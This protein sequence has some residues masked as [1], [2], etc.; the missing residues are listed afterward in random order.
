MCA[1]SVKRLLIVSFFAL[2]SLLAVAQKETIV[3]GQIFDR[4][5]QQPIAKASIGFKNT[6][7]VTESNDEGY[8]LLRG[9]GVYPFLTVSCKGYKNTRIHIKPNT[10]AEV[11]VWLTSADPSDIPLE[12]VIEDPLSHYVVQQA[13]QHKLFN[14]PPTGYSPTTLSERLKAYAYH[15]PANWLKDDKIKQGITWPPDSL[16]T[17]PLFT[18]DRIYRQPSFPSLRRDRSM[19]KNNEITILPLDKEYVEKLVG[20]LTLQQNFYNEHVEILGKYFLSPLATSARLHYTY[21]LQDSLVISGRRCYRIGFRPRQKRKLLLS[22]SMVID[23][24]SWALVQMDANIPPTLSV[25]FVHRFNIRQEFFLYRGQWYYKKIN[26]QLVMELPA[27]ISVRQKPLLGVVD[28]EQLFVQPQPDDKDLQELVG[29]R[30]P[31][32]KP[33]SDSLYAGV[34]HL[35]ET[36]FMKEIKWV[37]DLFMYQYA[38]VGKIDIGPVS[39]LYHRNVIDGSMGA[40]SLRTGESMWKNFSVGGSVGYAIDNRTWKFGGQMQYRFPTKAFQEIDF[41]YTKNTYQTGF[42]ENIFLVDENKTALSD[43]DTFASL[44]RYKP[45]YTVNEEGA[46]KVQYQREWSREFKTTVTLFDNR[47]YSNPYVQ[48]LSPQGD[49]MNS[50]WNVGGKI[51]FRFSQDQLIW[52]GFFGR[53]FLSSYSPVFH[54]QVE[55]GTY[56]VGNISGDYSRIHTTVSQSIDFIGGNLYYT[57]EAGYIFGRV[58]FPLL[59]FARGNET[60]SYS[61]YNF[62]LMNNLE[63]AGDKYLHLYVDY[64]SSGFLLNRLPIIKLLHLKEMFSLHTAENGLRNDHAQLLALPQGVSPLNTPYV[65]AGAGIYNILSCLGIQSVW[66]LTHRNEPGTSNWGL[67]ALFYLNF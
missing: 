60:Y 36:D 53:R 33:L 35:N 3:F 41:N 67:R 32:R 30:S 55:G 4:F 52:D 58:P 49:A 6:P 42:D 43:D 28:K 40:L 64:Y 17:I 23:S 9:N 66:R 26:T 8:F 34:G 54:L 2:L 11:N 10:S 15:V 7:I 29:L 25:N 51:D 21:F 63:Y 65:E 47:T 57:A 45:N 39:S 12:K 44:F 59:C 48:F 62:N 46:W 19:L 61:Q 27:P 31:E 14:G 5:T 38:H 13:V 24:Q 22:G 56:T 1:T 18:A 16:Y 50:I 20:L 37:T